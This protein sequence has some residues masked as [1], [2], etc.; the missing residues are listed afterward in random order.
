MELAARDLK[1]VSLELGGKS[2]NI[3]FADADLRRRRR[4]SPMSV[5]ANTG[6]DCCARSRVFVE[7]PVFDEFVETFVAAT[8]AARGRRSRQGGNANRSARFRQ[9]RETV[10]EFLATREDVAHK[11]ALRRRPPV[12]QGFYLDPAVLLGCETTDRFWREEIFGPVVCIRPSTTKPQMLREVNAS[13]YGLSGSIW[14]NDLAARVARRA[15]RRERRV[16]R[17]LPLERPR[18]SAVRRLQA[19]RPRPRSRH[20]RAWKV[21]RN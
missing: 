10:E 9:Q 20:D 16:E 13:P 3:I 21:T 7:R 8:R 4:S 2:P 5:F 19:K 12:A 15:A 17:Q 1:R 14:T 11:F 6:Q 18:R